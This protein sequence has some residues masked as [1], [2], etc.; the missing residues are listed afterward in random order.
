MVPYTHSKNIT[1]YGNI[2]IEQKEARMLEIVDSIQI[3]L[4]FQHTGFVYIFYQDP[5]LIPYIQRQNLNHQEKMTFVPNLADT[6][7][8]LFYFA[9]KNLEGK[10]TMILNADNYPEEGFDKVN[11]TRLKKERLFYLISRYSVA[12][13]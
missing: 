6:M 5:L 2:T 9:N 11:P 7:S 10:T 12:L 1:G 8:T 4:N 3:T 13:F